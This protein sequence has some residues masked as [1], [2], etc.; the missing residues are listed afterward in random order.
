MLVWGW[1]SG[2]FLTTVTLGSSSSS[3]QLDS[4]VPT[5]TFSVPDFFSSAHALAPSCRTQPQGSQRRL[6][7]ERRRSYERFRKVPPL[8]EDFSEPLERVPWGGS[9]LQTAPTKPHS[10]KCT[11][12]K[13]SLVGTRLMSRTP[14]NIQT[15]NAYRVEGCLTRG[16]SA[17]A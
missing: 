7:T 9:S 12:G 17:H 4:R 6:S 5:R 10:G 3:L 14:Y 11:P 2:T 16:E 1:N 8:L 13:V 15:L